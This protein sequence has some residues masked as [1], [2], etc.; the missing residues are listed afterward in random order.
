[1]PDF[2]FASRHF[3]TFGLIHV[4]LFVEDAIEVCQ[5]DVYLMYFPIIDCC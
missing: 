2:S 1:M 5:F 3:E 4:D